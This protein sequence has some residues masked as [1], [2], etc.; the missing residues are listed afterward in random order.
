[1]MRW[2]VVLV[3]HRTTFTDAWTAGESEKHFVGCC[4]YW[5]QLTGNLYMSEG[6]FLPRL[7]FVRVCKIEADIVDLYIGTNK[8][9]VP[10]SALSTLP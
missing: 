9:K 5:R 8:M 10:A 6:S 4:K 7:T 2:V 3:L 1:M